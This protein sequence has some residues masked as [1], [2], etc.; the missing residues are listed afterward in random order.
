[1]RFL[2][3]QFVGTLFLGCFASN[4]LPTTGVIQTVA[5]NDQEIGCIPNN[6]KDFTLSVTYTAKMK[7]THQFFVVFDNTLVN[8]TDEFHNDSSYP[9]SYVIRDITWNK[10]I[11]TART[12]KTLTFTIPRKMIMPKG[13]MFYIYN[14]EYNT[15]MSS[16]TNFQTFFRLDVQSPI[17]W[18]L[19]AK[20]D[21]YRTSTGYTG[22]SIVG[23]KV[24]QS[25]YTIKHVGFED[26]FINPEKNRIPLEDIQL[27]IL[28]YKKE[29]VAPIYRDAYIRVT[30]YLDDFDIFP[31]KT[32]GYTSWREIPVEFEEC[33]NSELYRL[34]LRSDYAV[35]MDG[36]TMK[37][38]I[39]KNPRDML[40]RDIYLPPVE[41]GD[42]KVFQFELNVIDT[43][44]NQLDKWVY[45]FD[46]TKTENYI[47]S[48]ISSTYCVGRD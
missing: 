35:T 4:A 3:K 17:T 45:R 13:N 24:Y 18:D 48:C 27:G 12:C 26:E 30:S 21:L 34:R 10:V 8:S 37:E 9:R 6:D 33:D 36:R 15:D 19:T 11:M 43:G 38:L 42:A 39:H 44:P 46:V 14:K 2:L 32:D 29:L 1:M 28:N 47:G 20:G 7:G 5:L 16:S 41:A 31:L 40:T 23:G 25:P 22:A